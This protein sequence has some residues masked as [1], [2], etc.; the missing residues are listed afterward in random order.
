[1]KR[2]LVPLDG[3]LRSEAILPVAEE[4]AKEDEAEV[5]LLRAV[6]ARHLPGRDPTE[7]EVRA[8]EEGEAYLKGVAEGLERRGLKGV[9][10]VVWYDE[11]TTAIA[12]AAAWDKV[13]LIAMATHGRS[14]LSRLML[15][16]V[17]EAVVRS[18]R[19][20]VL[21]LRGQSAWEPWVNGTILV[22]LG[23]S[24][25][26]EAILP[27]VERLAAPRGLVVSLLG[28]VEP[29]PSGVSTEIPLQTEELMAF[30]REGVELHLTKVAERLREKGLRVEWAVKFGRAAETIVAAAAEKRP[31]LIAMV[32]QGRRGLGRL[33]FGSVAEGVLRSAAVPVLLLKA[34]AV[35]T[36]E[37]A[38]YCP[39]AEQEVEV[40][41]LALDG[42][43]PIGVTS[44]TAFADPTRVICGVPPSCITQTRRTPHLHENRLERSEQSARNGQSDQREF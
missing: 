3:S 10:W 35:R 9:R 28:V 6:L 5:I 13:D 14:G 32:T 30:R 22:P 15:G 23:G 36:V 16:S 21:L 44:C 18:S 34:G 8:I 17:A 37:A 33:F 12:E 19:V 24:E 4:W 39:W 26:A 41:Y 7:A 43:R 11:P 20:P 27:V 2:M 38:F 31:D 42:P 25:E 40:R 1:M 29:L